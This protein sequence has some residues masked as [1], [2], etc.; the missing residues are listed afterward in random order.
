MPTDAACCH[1]SKLSL[2]FQVTQ[3]IIG[4]VGGVTGFR[5]LHI[6]ST[7]TLGADFLQTPYHGE[8]FQVH[9]HCFKIV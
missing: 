9:R 7:C 2:H 1:D 4:E 8:E 5:W 3:Q 6:S